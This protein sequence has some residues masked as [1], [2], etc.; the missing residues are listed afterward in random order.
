[1]TPR[2]DVA[3]PQNPSFPTL[4]TLTPQQD[5]ALEA[6]LSG[7]SVTVTAERVGVHRS[8]I[9]EWRKQPE[10]IAAFNRGRQEQVQAF[11][12]RLSGLSD[13]AFQTLEQALDSGDVKAATFVLRE[14]ARM[15]VESGSTDAAEIR[16]DQTWNALCR[17]MRAPA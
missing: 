15:P 6:L 11:A 13:K 14:L 16:S 4:D 7:L 8:T 9:H 10:F 3:M 12:G 1:M 5:A 2:R 17:E